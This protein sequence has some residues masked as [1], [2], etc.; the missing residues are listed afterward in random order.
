MSLKFDALM[1]MLNKLDRKEKITV[2][3]LM[4]DLEIKERSVHRYIDTLLT[5]GFPVYYDRTKA[6]YAFEEGY[7]L[8]KPNFSVEERLAFSL[9]KHFL[10]NFGPA[11]EMNLHRI[12]EKVSMP[13]RDASKYIVITPEPLPVDIGE[14][15]AVIHEAAINFQRMEVLYGALSTGE[16]ILRKV[17]PYYLFYNDGFWQLRGFCHLR[18][19]F[20]TFALDRVISLTL[21]DEY[22]LPREISLETELSGL[23]GAYV[24]G[25]STEVVLRFQKDIRQYFERRK[26]HYSQTQRDL[27]DGRL[28]VTFT[29]HGIEGVRHWIYRWLPHV[30]VVAPASL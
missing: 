26:W 16:A 5:A 14:R 3:S 28:E 7:T 17:D 30:E 6:S 21:L 8:R 19:E 23:F 20:R 11:M 4:D 9:A 2:K 13:V 12:E 18:K 1:T 15:L 22:F 24:D 27:P 10:R 29:A 25:E